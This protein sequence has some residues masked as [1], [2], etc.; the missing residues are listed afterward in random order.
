MTANSIAHDL[1]NAH[2]RRDKKFA[3]LIDPDDSNLRH[4]EQ[5]MNLA[6]GQGV[7]YILIGG[8]LIINDR[9]EDCIRR[10]K[11]VS[12][13]PVILFPGSMLQVCPL[14]DAILFLNL[15]SGRNPEYLI[16]QQVSAAPS[17]K[18]A[19]LEV[20]S[21]GYMLIDGGRPSSAQY[22][23]HT[24]PI[25]S[26]KTDIAVATALAGEMIGHSAIFM[27]AG[28]GA[29]TPVSETMIQEVRASVRIPLIVGGGLQSA[30]VVYRKAKAGADLIVVGNAIEKDPSLILEMTQAL[31]EA[32]VSI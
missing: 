31:K 15:I 30:E 27:D 9:L 6:D 12:E 28:S 29:E 4:F 20:I 32:K 25:P 3:V 13:I 22:I 14:A 26:E 21:T 23:S 19:G 17:I 11:S 24:L 8:S 7:D 10:I 18:K 5:I 16:G 1:V 2:E